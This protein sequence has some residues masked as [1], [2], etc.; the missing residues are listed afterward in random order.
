[1]A[2]DSFMEWKGEGAGWSLIAEGEEKVFGGSGGSQVI[3]RKRH[4]S[5]LRRQRGGGWALRSGNKRGISLR[6]C[7]KNVEVEGKIVCR[8]VRR[9]RGGEAT[10]GVSRKKIKKRGL[11]VKINQAEA[12]GSDIYSNTEK[13]DEKLLTNRGGECLSRSFLHG[14]TETM[15]KTTP[16]GIAGEGKRE[17]RA[18]CTRFQPQQEKGKKGR[19]SPERRLEGEKNKRTKKKKARKTRRRRK[20]SE[21]DPRKVDRPKGRMHVRIQKKGK[22]KNGGSCAEKETKILATI[23]M[24]QEESAH[25][26]G[27]P[28]FCALSEER[29][30]GEK[31]P[32][33]DRAA[34]AGKKGAWLP[35]IK[36]GQQKPA[37]IFEAGN[38]AKK[39]KK[40]GR[41]TEKR[42][43]S[44]RVEKSQCE[45]QLP[46]KSG[47]PTEEKK[48]SEGKRA[49]HCSKETAHCSGNKK[50]QSKERP[51]VA[52]Q[53]RGERGGKGT[54]LT[55]TKK[56]KASSQFAK[57]V[58]SIG[59]C[60]P[61]KGRR[62]NSNAGGEQKNPPLRGRGGA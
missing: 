62:R 40:G 13:E 36:K 51:C 25:R 43:V 37:T 35:A 56:K 59:D 48:K 52:Q 53:K 2:R 20:E 15:L 17:V 50:K 19:P 33:A 47:S 34:H 60:A 18:I 32:I 27:R 9:K 23:V 24:R 4:R 55:P 22:G 44:W 21:A 61:P 38:T 5:Q 12:V 49:R 39:K 31:N 1:L 46:S 8:Q 57:K 7:V 28:R 26:G 41:A 11:P 45:K 30:Q 58:A 10:F 14:L 6:C 3:G 42:G 16:V 54:V 29:K